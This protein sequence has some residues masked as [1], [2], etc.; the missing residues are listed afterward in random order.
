MPDAQR[1]QDVEP[2][3]P[4]QQ[5]PEG[6]SGK[7]DRRV[8][9]QDQEDGTQRPH[10]LRVR[11]EP[12]EEPHRG[13]GDGT[14]RDQAEQDV[15][16]RRRLDR[17]SRRCGV[18]ARLVR[19]DVLEQCVAQAD[20]YCDGLC[21]GSSGEGG[22]SGSSSSSG[23]GSTCHDECTE[24]SAMDFDCSGCTEAICN[25]DPYCCDTEWDDVCVGMVDELCDPPC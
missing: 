23:G 21:G 8:D 13:R 5:A 18:G 10:L 7:A 19:G 1:V 9:S 12:R 3:Q 17:A 11:D 15:Q 2:L 22:G 16:K 24:G 4:L 25:E 6:R 14:A 20:Q